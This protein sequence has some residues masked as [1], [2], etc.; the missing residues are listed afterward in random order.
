MKPNRPAVRRLPVLRD[1][2]V[3]G[4]TQ[5]LTVQLHDLA[6]NVIYS[7]ELPPVRT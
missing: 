6:G 7:I 5:V 4:R 2:A 3:E 1:A